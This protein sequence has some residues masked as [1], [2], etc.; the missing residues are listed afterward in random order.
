MAA[1]FSSLMEETEETEAE[2]GEG[3]ETDEG[4]D[5]GATETAEDEEGETDDEDARVVT[6]IPEQSAPPASGSQESEGS[7]TQA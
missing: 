5:D 2:D 1:A 4:T 7:S 3:L 6:H